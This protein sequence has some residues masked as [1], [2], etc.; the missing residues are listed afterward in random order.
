MNWD[1]GRKY[2]GVWNNFESVLHVQSMGIDTSASFHHYFI[3]LTYLG[4]FNSFSHSH[5]L[6]V[7]SQ[8]EKIENRKEKRKKRKIE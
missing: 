4:I 1:Y 6:T 2:A 8:R 7:D 3:V 5:S